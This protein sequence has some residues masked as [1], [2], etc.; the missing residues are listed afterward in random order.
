MAR[1]NY[2]PTPCFWNCLGI[3][4]AILSIGTSWNISRTK[5]FEME[6]A[7]YKLKTGSALSKVQKANDLT[8]ENIETLPPTSPQRIEAEQDL[9]TSNKLLKEAEAQ[10]QQET[11]ELIEPAAKK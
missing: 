10:I 6:L 3:A 9:Q 2:Y 1:L 5:V 4:I 11:R 8:A 7:E